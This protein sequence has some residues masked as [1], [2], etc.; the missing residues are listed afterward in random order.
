MKK[1][2]SMLICLILTVGI[3]PFSCF[4]AETENWEYTYENIKWSFN[5]ESGTMTVSG[6]GKMPD[7]DGLMS[8]SFAYRDDSIRHVVIEEGITY[9][10]E[11]S[12]YLCEN[13]ETI[14]LP[15]SLRE[16]GDYAFMGSAEL[17][18]ELEIPAGVREIGLFAF[19]PSNNWECIRFYGNPPEIAT[20]A[21]Y[22]FATKENTLVMNFNGIIY[23]PWFAEGWTVPV[24][25][26]YEQSPGAMIIWKT[27]DAPRF[28][29]IEEIFLDLS[30]SSWYIPAVDYVYNNNIM[31]GTESGFAPNAK[32]TREEAIQILYNIDGN[33][34][35][36]GKE[37]GFTDVSV[38]HWAAPAI[39]WAKKNGITQGIGNGIF[40]LGQPL[41]REQLATLLTNYADK[42]G[43][44]ITKGKD[45]SGF[46]D[47][48]NVS[49]WAKDGLSYCAEIGVIKG[50]DKNTILP[51]G[52]ASRAETA[53]MF[54][55]YFSYKSSF[56]RISFNAC[57]GNCEETV[58]FVKAGDTIGALPL[59]T[60]EGYKF[61]GWRD[62]LNDRI[63]ADT[64]I[65]EDS[66]L[67]A[68]WV[69]GNKVA[70]ITDG[71]ECYP[72]YKYVISGKALGS[73]P[74]PHREGYTFKGWMYNGEI[75]D[76]YTVIESDV[77]FILT[78]LWEE[79][80]IGG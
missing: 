14:S 46:N 51:K 80:T 5:A 36:D 29:H 43:F 23:Y 54:C 71:G 65:T 52:L 13:I 44:D 2:I 42:I 69:Q 55:N 9:I 30:Y 57:E 73:L 21:D 26:E 16:I 48:E 66:V 50:T 38:K 37:T 76:A 47:H 15:K 39:S 62:Q 12:F 7:Y 3:I 77:D 10:G 8:I 19:N 61:D 75:V 64:V 59:P 17:L 20:P 79:N 28:D 72:L 6:M 53:Q 22:G 56:Y 74:V 1:I 4:G 67:Y 78:A 70:F 25:V 45:L 40:G 63:T 60:K 41:T 27:W 68:E 32:L 49:D 24:Q 31:K 58:R 33:N 35:W 11:C 18:K 34:Y